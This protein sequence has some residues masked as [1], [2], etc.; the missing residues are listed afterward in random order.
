MIRSFLLGLAAWFL[1][2]WAIAVGIVVGLSLAP[3][4]A[5]VEPRCDLDCDACRD[6]SS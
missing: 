6:T 2:T 5:P 4:S 1:L 3:Q